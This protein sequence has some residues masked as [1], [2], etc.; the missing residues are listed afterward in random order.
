MRY[1][2]DISKNRP[3]GRKVKPKGGPSSCKYRETRAFL[4]LLL[5]DFSKDT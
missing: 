5:L 4:L 1:T 3:G 2:E